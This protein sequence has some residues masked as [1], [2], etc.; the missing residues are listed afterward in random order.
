M[1]RESIT[2]S[3]SKENLGGQLPESLV[4]SAAYPGTQVSGEEDLRTIA[5]IVQLR[6]GT[7]ITRDCERGLVIEQDRSS[8]LGNRLQRVA[9]DVELND[10]MDK[11][12]DQL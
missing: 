2:E 8:R 4:L 7:P 3:I 1:P 6:E 5:V 12:P 9:T 11:R 10:D